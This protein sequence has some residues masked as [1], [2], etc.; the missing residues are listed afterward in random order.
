MEAI[1][2]EVKAALKGQIPLHSFRMWI[3]SIKCIGREGEQVTLTCPN[4][5]SRKRVQ[6]HYAALI[7]A[8]FG[9]ALG[10]ACRVAFE[11]DS[12]PEA[13]QRKTPAGE[14][15]R[16]PQ[17]G[18]GP[19]NGRLLCRD[20]TFERFVVAGSNDFAFSAALSLASSRKRSQNALFLL[21]KTG[22]GKSHLTQ[23]V[24]NHVLAE[25]PGQRVYYTTADDFSQ[26]MV[27]AY[28]RKAI[29]QFKEKYR[30][31]CDVLL[32]E[33]IHY[34]SG[35]NRTQ[36]EL[37]F[38]LDSLMEMGKKII[39]SSTFAPAEIPGLDEK[40]RSRLSSSLV[41][42]IDPPTFRTRVRILNAKAKAGGYAFPDE[43]VEY[44][45]SELTED[46]RQL[47]SGMNHVAAKSRLMGT[48]IDLGLAESVVQTIVS[49]RENIT[50]DQLKKLVCKEFQ[51]SAKDLVSRSRKH[52]IVR[53][54]QIAMFLARRYTDSPLQMIGRSFNRYHATVLHSI[55]AVEK[56]AKNKGTLYKQLQYLCGKIESGRI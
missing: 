14:Q 28:Q 40:L 7:E 30:N 54:R 27:D 21:S 51:V 17:A 50:I 52:A 49:Q 4:F 44:L 19:G 38:S 31:G 18:R 20:F 15:L 8:A 25:F 46:V 41:S 47:E 36:V 16:L 45:A 23:A 1:W 26:E 34:L 22:L 39:F 37:A 11:I 33:D 10:E 53:P 2:K 43:V 24:G 3:E 5:F 55:S 12:C 35:K 32:L 48:P 42:R 6:E 9:T 13:G 56:E 29:H